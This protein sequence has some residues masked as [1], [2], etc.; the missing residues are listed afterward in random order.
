MESGQQKQYPNSSIFDEY[1]VP[2]LVSEREKSYG[3]GK[4]TSILPE[5][6]KS[7]NL[8]SIVAVLLA[9]I[10]SLCFGY[11]IGY[12]SP[13]LLDLQRDDSSVHLDKP[14]GAF[15]ASLV[16]LGAIIGCP[17]GGV[18]SEICGR[19]VTIMIST[20]PFTSG[21]LM[22][23]FAVNMA[24]LDGGRLLTGVGCGMIAVSY[25]VYVAEIASSKLRGTLGSVH[26]TAITLGILL[27]YV[28]GVFCDWRDTA[29]PGIIMPALLIPVMMFLTDTPRWYLQHNKR[30]KALKALMWLRGKSSITE[31]ECRETEE[32][33]AMHRNMLWKEF[34]RPSITRPLVIGVGLMIFQ[35]TSGGIVIIMN[36][37]SI[38][39]SAG[40]SDG[41]AVSISI[42]AVQLLVNLLAS[43]VIYRVGRRTL[44]V[45]MAV[46]M[47]IC[48]FG[49]G[50]FFQLSSNEACNST[51][52]HRD[53]SHSIPACE[54]SWL[55][56]TCIII[57]NIAFSIAW[58][59]IPWIIISEIFPLRA[60]SISG[61]IATISAFAS[62]FV[63][64]WCY[65]YMQ[66][67]LTDS[68][69]YW[70]YGGCCLLSSLFVFLLVPETRGQTLEEIENSFE[71]PRTYSVIE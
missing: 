15:F 61:S 9:G 66:Y 38:F 58:G 70:F 29:I 24:M 55:A 45:S 59:P 53:L 42:A 37:A 48:H 62:A 4:A 56:I 39:A 65:P 35:Q 43:G 54:I 17:V 41:K 22:I 57:F 6:V 36:C 51:V 28:V 25:P 16:T 14:E 26:Q 32:S 20:I 13:A 64:L 44:L 71:P 63:L 46:V 50:T 34:C 7:S 19:K 8:K 1:K 11:C 60:R 67:A 33:I 2:I 47:A 12:S 52:N 27:S 49:I 5:H 18:L 21:W 40:F 10:G 69:L 68:G 23:Q 31:I 30:S 3:T